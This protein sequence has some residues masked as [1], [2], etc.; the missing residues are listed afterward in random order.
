[1]VPGVTVPYWDSSLDF[2]IPDPTQSIIWTDSFLGNGD[3]AVT[4]G[5]F[6]NWRTASGPL[7]RN[8]GSSSRLYSKESLQNILTRTRMS[9]IS[10]PSASAM[11]NLEYHHNGPHNWVDG[12]MAGLETAP[13]DPVF[14]MH[15]AYVDYLWELFR[16]RQRQFGVDPSLDYPSNYGEAVHAPGN[17]MDGMAQYTNVQGYDDFWMS[18]VYTYDRAPSCSWM[19]PDCG[20]RYLRCDT[21]RSRCVSTESNVNVGRQLP[22]KTFGL[23]TG[24]STIVEV[25]MSE[26]IVRIRIGARFVGPPSD[27]R[28]RMRRNVKTADIQQSVKQP[29]DDTNITD[30]ANLTVSKNND[31]DKDSISSSGAINHDTCLKSDIGGAF[32]NTFDIDGISDMNLW[33]FL[34]VTIIHQRPI[35]AKFQSYAVH[36]G[37][38]DDGN[39]IYSP[40]AHTSLYAHLHSDSSDPLPSCATSPSGA[41]KVF[42]QSD[43]ISYMGRYK[44][45]A[46]IDHRQ[47]ITTT[48]SYVAVMDPQL[49]ST[50]VILTAYDSC[51]RICHPRCRVQEPWS[52]DYLPCSGVID[53]TSV[54]PRQY[55]FSYSDA[56]SSV[57]NFQNRD[58]PQSSNENLSVAFYCTNE[59]RWPWSD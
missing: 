7:T 27:G 52:S 2:D 46:V 57:W 20:S 29:A 4:T 40:P 25:P 43:G 16:I 58:F 28:S 59:D 55:A 10:Y 5:P 9:E 26:D 34:P 44:D 39:D 19:Q 50:S 21:G 17:A 15:H 49:G 3:G 11:Y 8:I 48:T 41:G 6:A 24:S 35:G 45:Y 30:K 18:T 14:Y 36:N 37:E 32:Q 13:Q 31:T 22:N 12:Q 53:V 56:V 23:A 1:M 38:I 33:V 42:V 54:S 47:P 51:G